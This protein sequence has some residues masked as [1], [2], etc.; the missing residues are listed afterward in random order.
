MSSSN[1]RDQAPEL[2]NR[3][4]SL[5][6]GTTTVRW[7]RQ[8][9]MTLV[10]LMVALVLGLILIGGVLNIF[11]ANRQTFR[12]NENLARMQENAR[13]AF[14]FMSRDIR[15]AG[16][17]PCGAKLIANVVRVSAAIPWWANWG[18]GTIRG[19][20]GTQDVTTMVAFGT[21]PNTRVAGTDAVLV[22]RSGQDEQ[23]ITAHDTA[24]FEITL[25]AITGLAANDIVMACDLRNAAIFQ[26][27][28]VSTSLKLIDHKQDVTNLNCSGNLIFPTSCPALLVPP[29]AKQFH[30][31]GMVAKLVSTFWYV[32]NNDSG[33]RSLYRTRIIKKTVAGV[34]VVTTEPEEM[35]TG[36]QN[37]KV[38]YLTKNVTT[39]TLANNWVA[40]NNTVFDVANGAWSETNLEQA[41]AARITMTLQSDESVG[42]NQQPIQRQLIHV[43]GL[44]SRDTLYQ[45]AAP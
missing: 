6:S 30:S 13:T 41:V 14:D 7:A 37:L 35:F 1:I 8:R 3:P 44:R 26:I 27:D 42:V 34:P 40:A 25:K 28:T 32:G 29:P 45:V 5:G 33:K 15:E 23:V 20:N 16:V 12:T 38:E 10:E 24:A 36:V 4:L 9:G 11:I 18:A 19:V 39:Q 43:V 22:I 31:N 21:A 17:N 2:L